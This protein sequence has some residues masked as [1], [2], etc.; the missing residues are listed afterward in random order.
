MRITL[1]ID[2]DVLAAARVRAEREH[3]SIGRILSQLARAALQPV[4]SAPPASHNGLPI[5]PNA[6]SA[7]HVTPELV[8]QLRDAAP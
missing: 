1:D 3:V 6:P 8:N 5:L 2:D 7:R 4:E